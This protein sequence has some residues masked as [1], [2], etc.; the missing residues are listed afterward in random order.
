MSAAH[1][2][3][4]AFQALE[5]QLA[6]LVAS[7][8]TVQAQHQA[9]VSRRGFLEAR[10]MEYR[11]TDSKIAEAE[12]VVKATSQ[13]RET[14]DQLALAFGRT[15]VQALLVEAAIPELE[16]EANLLLARMTDNLMHLK[17]ETRRENLRGE[18]VETL[19]I[20]VSDPLGTRS[21]ETFSGGEAFR[22][23]LALRIGLSKLLAHRAGAPL[24]TLFIDEGFGTQDAAGRERILEV[25]QSISEDFACILVITHMDEVKGAFPVRIEVQK[26]PS[27]S[28]FTLT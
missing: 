19:E 3:V 15:G 21:Y 23:N 8:Q 20:K 4:Q 6:S 12:N 24:P 2:E 28:T 27:G 10:L 11:E 17:L 13:E 18:P 9:L 16:A 7:Q 22:I 25:I 1:L 14:F 5:Q 26:A